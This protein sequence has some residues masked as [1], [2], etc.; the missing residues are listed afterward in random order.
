LRRRALGGRQLR[1]DGLR[2]RRKLEGPAGRVGEERLGGVARSRTGRRLD[3]DEGGLGCARRILLGRGRVSDRDPFLKQL[4]SSIN[5][6][7]YYNKIT[8]VI[9]KCL[10][11]ASVFVPCRPFQPILMYEGK[12]KSLS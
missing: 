4:V 1:W 9:Y 5:L 3:C 7:Q 11:K 12:A 2:R 8:T 10:L 6:D